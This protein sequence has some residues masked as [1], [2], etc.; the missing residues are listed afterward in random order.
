M[1]ATLSE[2]ARPQA[3]DLP[4]DTTSFLGR[5]KEISEVKRL[6]STSRMVTLVGP[7]G[8]GKTRLAIRVAADA[9]R[10]FDDNVRLVELADLRD[11]SLLA[12]TV[13]DKLGVYLR[14]EQSAINSIADYLYEKPTLL[15]LD[16]CEHLTEECAEL[17]STLIRAC[18]DL[19]VLATSR[20]SLGLLGESTFTVE[21]F[22]VP[23]PDQVSSAQ[24]LQDYD[25]VRLFTERAQAIEPRFRVTS[26]NYKLLAR[27]CNKIDGIPLAIELAVTGLRSLSL[28]QLV[29]RLATGYLG[30]VGTRRDVPERQRTMRALI[31]W[32]YD[33]CSDAERMVWARASVF[34]GTFDLEAIEYVASSP[35]LPPADVMAVVTALTDKSIFM[36]DNTGEQ[37][38]YRM[39]APTKEYGAEKLV[40]EGDEL[41]RRRH[42]DW[43]QQL[44]DQFAAEWI[45]P[46][47]AAWVMRWRAEHSN[48]RAALSYCMRE[49]DDA[50]IALRMIAQ[51]HEYWS[52]RGFHTEA[53]HWID[54][55]L[56]RAPELAP[57]RI[58]ALRVASS[59]AVLQGDLEEAMRVRDQAAQLA[60]KIGDEDE[61]ASLKHLPGSIS[62]LAN[63]VE[64]A[65]HQLTDALAAIQATGRVRL[66][67]LTRLY[68][69]LAL[70]ANGEPDDGIAMLRKGIDT[71]AELGEVYWRSWCQA[72]IAYLEIRRDADSAEKLAKESLRLQYPLG[73]RLL[74]TFT[75]N[76]LACATEASGRHQRAA[77]LFG[78]ASALWKTIGGSTKRYGPIARPYRRFFK[79][80]R[81]ALSEADFNAA[82]A[83]GERQPISAIVDY[84]LE[85][86]TP[87]SSDT[88][89]PASRSA[90]SD[91]NPLT[92]REQEIAA[93][94]A[95]G[96]TNREIATTL[97]ISQRTAEAHVEHILSKLG[98]TSR[99]QIATWIASQKAAGPS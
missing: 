50:A 69:G 16:N 31:D 8:V 63:D 67:L 33:H 41:P 29:D 57:E 45:G 4:A 85:I 53:R 21:G 17:V 2:N 94:V 87:T 42:R 22:R 10:A 52:V 56:A 54:R 9:R 55:A 25:S 95:E 91:P 13:A 44:T 83:V 38:R 18:P 24:Q 46:D 76:L 86:E 43:Y 78:A 99:T 93:L 48:L 75:L 7:G 1:T 59:F 19:R 27:L 62:L 60:R 58:S 68:L 66:E 12:N 96:M 6:L 14:T 34:S 5:R 35:A 73:N 36:R 20:Q 77:T 47:Q 74:M 39:L 15:V 64:T 49:P 40:E 65:V 82:F 92:R 30:L 51:L 89:V 81:E 97:V 28:E 61:S 72:G 80:T 98:Y 84:A 32:S 88:N 71:A 11:P 90:D 79:R 26:A 37:M 70:G 23:D 3:G